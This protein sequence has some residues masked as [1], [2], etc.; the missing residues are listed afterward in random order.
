MTLA[1]T[2]EQHL[3]RAGVPY[4]LVDHPYTEGA[5]RTAEAAHLPGDEVLKCVL[6]GDDDGYLMAVVA[7]TQ[8]VDLDLVHAATGRR[9]RLVEEEEVASV[10][11][12][13]EIGSVP[14][15]GEAYGMEMLVDDS[16]SL[17]DDIYFESGEHTQLVHLQ[18]D[19]FATLTAGAGHA[20]IAS[21]I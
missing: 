16:L 11:A 7:A 9:L 2:L 18:G 3:A 6:L 13:C 8:R 19:A 21:H 4:D 1:A 20:A 10:F 15:I 17:R 5:S 12:D 14:P